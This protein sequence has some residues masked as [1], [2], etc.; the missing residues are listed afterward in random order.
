MHKVI[1]ST[2]LPVEPNSTNPDYQT[3]TALI[4]TFIVKNHVN[5]S[6]NKMAETWEAAFLKYV[7]NYTGRHINITYSAEASLIDVSVFF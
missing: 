3:A 2:A 1:P 7:S 5:E 4:I 6:D